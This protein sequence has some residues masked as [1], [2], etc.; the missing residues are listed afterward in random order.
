MASR[1]QNGRRCGNEPCRFEERGNDD[2]ERY[3][4]N[5]GSRNGETETDRAF[6]FCRSRRIPGRRTVVSGTDTRL[7]RAQA[8]GVPPVRAN[9][10]DMSDREPE[11]QRQSQQRKPRAETARYGV[12]ALDHCLRSLL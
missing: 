10:M 5:K 7:R 2:G 12:N 11:L 3:R 1:Q 4:E 9:L 8:G 6:I